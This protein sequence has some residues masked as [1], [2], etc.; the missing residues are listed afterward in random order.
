MDPL[1]TPYQPSFLQSSRR[2]TP[3]IIDEKY[4]KHLLPHGDGRFWLITNPSKT[5]NLSTRS[6][7]TAIDYGSTLEDPFIYYPDLIVV[8]RLSDIVFKLTN[9]GYDIDPVMI[10]R[11]FWNPL[12]PQHYEEIKKHTRAQE[13]RRRSKQKGVIPWYMNP[14]SASK[15]VRTEPQDELEQIGRKVWPHRMSWNKYGRKILL[16]EMSWNTYGRKV[17]KIMILSITGGKEILLIHF[18]PH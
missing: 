15:A 18:G 17:T 16:H 1:Y 11:R 9:I 4:H 5:Y 14:E 6:R 10:L 2:L 12:S 13:K 8:G 3:K 7:E